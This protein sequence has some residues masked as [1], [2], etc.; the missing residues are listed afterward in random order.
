MIGATEGM[1]TTGANGTTR[2]YMDLYVKLEWTFLQ[3]IC[4]PEKRKLSIIVNS[5]PS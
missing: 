4:T 3:Q 2:V 5:I 1:G